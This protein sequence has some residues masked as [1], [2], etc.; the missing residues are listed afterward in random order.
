MLPVAVARSSSDGCAVRN[1]LC[2]SG[3]VDDVIFWHNGVNRPESNRTRMCRLVRQ[4][5]A[6]VRRQ[7]TLFGWV[8]QMSAP[9]VKSAISGC[10]LLKI[11]HHIADLIEMKTLGIFDILDEENRLP[12]ASYDHFTMEVHR[13]N[14][15]H[16]RL[17]V[18]IAF[19]LCDC[20]GEPLPDAS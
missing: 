7:I 13:K 11:W 16:Y 10:I 6:P 20:I 5:V 2:T 12:K 9:G 4:V 18:S 19:L 14:K 8:R 17:S 3:F 1:M 15:N